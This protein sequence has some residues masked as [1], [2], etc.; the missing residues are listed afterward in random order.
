MIVTDCNIQVNNDRSTADK[1]I[2]VYRGDYNVQ[3]T[4]TITQSNNYRYRGIDSSGENLI[5]ST[6][7]SYGQIL[8]KNQDGESVFVISEIEPTNEG[9]VTLTILGEYINE[10]VELGAYD[11]QI[12]LFSAEKEARLTIPPVEG[13]LIVK[14]PLIFGDQNDGSKVGIAQ[15]NHAIILTAEEDVPT[16]DDAGS[17]NKT[18]WTNGDIITD[19]KLNKIEDALAVLTDE[20]K[21]HATTNY[22]D[23]AIQTI[24]LTPGPKGDTGEQGPKGEQGI[25]GEQGVQGV[26]G[27]QGEKGD[28]GAAFTYDMFT[29]E[30]LEA[31]RGPKGDTGEQGPKGDKGDQGEPGPAGADGKDGAAFTYDMFTQEQLEALRGPKGDK[32]DQGEK[33]D[34]PSLDGYATEQYVNEAISN[35]EIGNV[36]LSTYVTKENPTMTGSLSLN[37]AEN[38]IIGDYSVAVG[39]NTVAGGNYSHAEGQ[40]TQALSDGSHAEGCNSTCMDIGAHAEGLNTIAR[41]MAAHVE[42]NG[43]E[44]T[45]SGHYAHV[46]GHRTIANGE[47]QHVQGRFN[48]EDT[49][50]KYAH[51]VGNGV[52]FNSEMKEERSNAHT[53]DWDG[54]AW[55]AGNVTIGA[56]NKELATKDDLNNALGDIESLLGGI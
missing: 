47:A 12:R 42:G 8:I 7:A 23:E 9:K 5:E 26:Q 15:V 2:I 39:F 36:D 18:Q 22:V 43:S 24:E 53:L 21:T 40:S 51:I 29:P 37:R 4:F 16:F 28:T 44:T 49:E 31:L 52:E 3:V 32:G 11:Y 41:G 6:N 45:Y 30:Q 54:N 46:E 14:E 27:V 33:G 10:L 48:I 13:Q 20:S 19:G 56:D 55:F 34:T 1:N 50:G 17:Y 25:Q 35:I 38:T